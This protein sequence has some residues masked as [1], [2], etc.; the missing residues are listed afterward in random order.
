[1]VV[2]EHC[3]VPE[4]SKNAQLN[5]QVYVLDEMRLISGILAEVNYKSTC[6]VVH[7]HTS[8]HHVH[9]VILRWKNVPKSKYRESDH[10]LL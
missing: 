3:N 7:D 2:R 4:S 9:R 10:T 5:V 6:H 1:M 8:L